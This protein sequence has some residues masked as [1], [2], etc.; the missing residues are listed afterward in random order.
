MVA[1]YAPNIDDP[2]RLVLVGDRNAIFDTKIDR[3]GWAARKSERCESSLINLIA[4]HDLVDRF[5]RD[6]PGREMWSWLDSS[7]SVCALSYLGRVLGELTLNSL[8]VTRSTEYGRLTIALLGSVC[9]WANRPNPAGYWKF[10]TSLLEIRDFR[11]RLKDLIQRVLVGAVTR[12]KYRIRD[13]AIIYGQQLKLDR[14]KI[15]K[16]LDDK[17]YRTVERWNSLAVDLTK[18]EREG[19]E[20]QKGFVVRYKLKR[21]LNKAMNCSRFAGE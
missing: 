12:N 7:P 6:H 13:F 18:R 5:S 10:K 3:V 14:N 9:G 16:S 21:V 20:C 17:F 11:D 2:K 19:S 15:E 8:W 4:W 1:V